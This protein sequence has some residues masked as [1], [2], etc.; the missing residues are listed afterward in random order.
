MRILTILARLGTEKYPEAEPQIDELF[1]Q[2]L[3]GVERE[4]VVVDNALPAGHL[5]RE[6]DRTL[7]GGDN[8]FWEF[9]AFDRVIEWLGPRIWAFDLVHLATSAFNTLYTAYLDRF[10]ATCLRAIAGR[11]VCLGHVDCYNEP[12]EVFSFRSQHWVRT[13]F[14]FLPPAELKALGTL[15]GTRDRARFF[16]GDPSC[17]FRADAPLSDAY[18]RLITSWLEGGDTGQGM[19]WHSRVAPS[20]EDLSLFEGKAIAIIN[21]HLLSIRL[22]AMGCRLIDVTWLS[23]R[24]QEAPGSGVAWETGWQRQLAERDRDRVFVPRTG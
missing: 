12:I 8:S 1:R 23:A 15:V 14:L 18:R 9:S 5:E 19:R 16:S 11:P 2:R 24:L 21:E 13:S 3:P 17:P 20:P 10:D 6:R 4:R 7:I 22:R